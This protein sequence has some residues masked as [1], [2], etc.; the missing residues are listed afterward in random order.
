M[1]IDLSKTITNNAFRYGYL[2][3]QIYP[4]IHKILGR[5]ILGFVIA[6]PLGL[7]DG[8]VAFSLKPY[9]DYV[10]NGKDNPAL[11]Q[12]FFHYLPFLDKTLTLQV[13]FAMIIP[14]GIV[15]R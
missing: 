9:L 5:I 3:K 6:I 10:I 13:V 2:L 1:N 8:V 15:D 12:W 11:L 14:F 4:Y 7:L